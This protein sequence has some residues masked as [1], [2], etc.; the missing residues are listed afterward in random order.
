MGECRRG[1][2]SKGGK[3]RGRARVD[4]VKKK[5]RVHLKKIRRALQNSLFG[6][7]PRVLHSPWVWKKTQF[8]WQLFQGGKGTVSKGTSGLGKLGKKPQAEKT[9]Q[10][11][12]GFEP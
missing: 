12:E 7:G 9:S 6:V 5:K 8:V 4:A 2:F 10:S 3:K 11:R 1:R